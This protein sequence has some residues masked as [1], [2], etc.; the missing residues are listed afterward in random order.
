MNGA[1]PSRLSVMCKCLV[2]NPVIYSK[3]W[4]E[5]REEGREK[6]RQG[7]KRQSLKRQSLKR[8]GLKRQSLKK[9]R[10][11]HPRELGNALSLGATVFHWCSPRSQSC[12]IG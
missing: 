4:T 8:Q 6:E 2:N 7:L 5:S 11:F 1:E 3:L 9:Q 10:G 12:T